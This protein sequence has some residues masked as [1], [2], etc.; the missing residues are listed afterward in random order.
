M[1]WETTEHPD[2]CPNCG[3]QEEVRVECDDEGE[4]IITGHRCPNGCFYVDTR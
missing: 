4:E 2:Y 3:A 1:R